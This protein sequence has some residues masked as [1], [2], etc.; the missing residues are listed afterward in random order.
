MTYPV[1]MTG[2]TISNTWEWTLHAWGDDGTEVQLRRLVA[3]LEDPLTLSSQHIAP[4]PTALLL[5]TVNIQISE[6]RA[7]DRLYV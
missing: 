4:L 6:H 1:K 3:S 7:H 2:C 5:K